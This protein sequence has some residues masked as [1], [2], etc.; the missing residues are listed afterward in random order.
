MTTT[1]TPLGQLVTP[2]AFAA[3]FEHSD[4]QE[5]VK[6]GRQIYYDME[7]EGMLTEAEMVSAVE[8]NLTRRALRVSEYF[9]RVMG[10]GPDPYLWRLGIVMGMIAEGC[11]IKAGEQP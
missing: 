4:F 10:M 7:Y 6:W 5:G 3:L 11:T 8:E 9:Y 1:T 2:Q